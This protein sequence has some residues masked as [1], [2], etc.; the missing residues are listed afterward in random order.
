MVCYSKKQLICGLRQQIHHDGEK[1]KRALLLVYENQ[2]REEQASSNTIEFNGIGFSSLDAEILSGIATFYKKSGF[3]TPRQLTI[4]KR[5]M[6]K[7]A[8]QIL[9]SSIER[10]LIKQV[11]PRKYTIC[12]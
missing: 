5:L 12:K 9:N 4:V 10:G 7:Y 1:A 2:T 6:P 11:S 8:V 3:V